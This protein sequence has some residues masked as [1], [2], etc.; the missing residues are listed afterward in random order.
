M[1]DALG[2]GPSSVKGMEVRV[3]SWAPQHPSNRMLFCIRRLVQTNPCNYHGTMRST[4]ETTIIR[5]SAIGILANLVLAAFKAFVGLAT[6]SIAVILDAVNNLSDAMSSVTTIIGTRLAGKA[7]DK[8][9]PFGYGRIEY[10]SATIVAVIVLYSGI[11]S[12][13]ESVK[14]IFHPE[15]ATYTDISLLIIAVAVLVK[16]LLGTYVQHQGKKVNSDSLVAS[17]ADAKFDAILSLS[18]FVCALLSRFTGLSLE[19]YVGVLIAAM[20]IKSGIEMTGKTTS[21]MLGE[22]ASSELSKGIKAVL[23]ENDRVRGAYDLVLNNYGPD[24]Y[25]ASVHIEVPDTMTACEI[26]SLSLELSRKVYQKCHVVL[27]AIGIYASNTADPASKAMREAVEALA[28]GLEGVLQIHGFHLN[29]KEKQVKFD[30]VVDYAVKDKE[31]LVSHMQ[32]LCRKKWPDYSFQVNQD[33]DI[34]D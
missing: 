14:K 23:E 17:G 24:Q 10:L 8:K 13:V 25:I 19:A 16:L 4:R 21:E 7:P 18:V 3:F 27:S 15:A 11:T 26:D 12:A 34:S 6:G 32:E 30:I 29:A 33:F 31:A 2:S 1:V 28:K 20:I 5:T 22:R 9:H